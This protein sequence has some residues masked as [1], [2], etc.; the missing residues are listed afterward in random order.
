MGSSE[1]DKFVQ[2]CIQGGRDGDDDC[3][4][5]MRRVIVRRPPYRLASLVERVPHEE[6]YAP[7]QVV[8]DADSGSF[9]V[10]QELRVA[11]LPPTRLLPKPVR[12][13]RAETGTKNKPKKAT[14]ALLIVT[15]TINASV[16]APERERFILLRHR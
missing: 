10:R 8:G 2:P 11:P 14:H 1:R 16:R 13:E 12:A 5:E 15:A 3:R 6:A 9:W 4:C 7:E